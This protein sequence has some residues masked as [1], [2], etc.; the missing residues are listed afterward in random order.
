MSREFANDPEERGSKTKE[1]V[2][3]AALINTQYHKVTI[4]GK[5]EQSK[6]WSTALPNTS[7]G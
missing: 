7:V 2:L 1:K 6:E 5:V 3:D 4:N